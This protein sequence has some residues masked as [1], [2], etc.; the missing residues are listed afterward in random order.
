VQDAELAQQAAT[1]DRAA[2]AAIYDRYA[3]R[4]YDYCWSILRDRHEAED[5]MH[6]AFVTAARKIE[7]LRDPALLRAWLYAICRNQALGRARRRGRETPSEDVADMSPPAVEA[8]RSGYE[9]EQLRTLVWDAAGGLAPR[10]RSVL[11]LHLRHGMEGAELGAALGT[12]AHHATVMLSRVR[13]HVERSLGALLVGRTGRRECSELD[14]LLTDWDGRLSPLLRKR[15]ARHIDNCETCG[16]R[17]SRMVSPLALLSGVPLLPAPEYL[18]E[19]VLADIEL[20]SN[21]GHLDGN[22]DDHGRLTTLRR[23]VRE[24][25]TGLIAGAAALTVL[26]IVGATLISLGRKGE[27]EPLGLTGPVVVTSADGSTS[28]SPSATSAATSSTAV[29]SSSATTSTSSPPAAVDVVTGSIDFGTSATDALLR[30][31]N[32]GGR[33]LPWS[34]SSNNRAVTMEPFNGTLAAGQTTA[35]SVRLNRGSLPEGE[36]AAQLKL[37]AAGN[38][39]VPVMAMENRAPTISDLGATASWLVFGSSAA[40]CDQARV[41]AMVAD[42]SPVTV[43]ISWQQG[44]GAQQDEPAGGSG[45]RYSASVGPITSGTGNLRWWVTATDSRGNVARSPEQSIEVRDTPPCP[46]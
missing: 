7:Q 44:S 18:R 46:T 8:D 23:S 40:P 31:R 3:D 29:S 6:D 33:P 22:P 15:V 35:I 24:G 32:T 34:V 36:F 12:N 1:G 4:L 16:A 43:S 25:R 26:A 45:G 37:V 19:R 10:D 30:F 14:G 27:P 38:T 41:S 20:A 5:T 42:D 2:W 11:E 21:G 39:T 17:R 13:E 28:A 9:L